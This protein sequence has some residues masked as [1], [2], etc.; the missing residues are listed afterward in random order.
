MM[1]TFLSLSNW[2]GRLRERLF[3]WKLRINLIGWATSS[4]TKI[5]GEN[6]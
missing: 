6:S 5:Q 1:C 4:R 2:G 3:T